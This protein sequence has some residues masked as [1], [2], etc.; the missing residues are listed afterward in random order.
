VMKPSLIVVLF[1]TLISAQS[2]SIASGTAGYMY[3]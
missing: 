1:S 2:Q 3:Y